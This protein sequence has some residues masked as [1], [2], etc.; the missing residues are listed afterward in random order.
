MRWN[1]V[2]FAILLALHAAIY[3]YGELRTLT[4]FGNLAQGIAL[5]LAGLQFGR[6]AQTS[7]ER[8]VRTFNFIALGFFVCLMGHG[9]LAYSEL[10]LHQPATG[11]V[12]DAIWL[13]GYALI[14]QSLFFRTGRDLVKARK[15]KLHLGL[16]TLVSMI[17]CV[18]LWLPLIDPQRSALTK[19]L[20]VIF[21]FLDFWI[22]AMAFVLY[23]RTG[24]RGWLLSGI[25]SLIIGIAD[26]V[27]PY[28]YE[29]ISPVYRYL[30]IPLFIGYSMW[31]LGG[32]SM[33]A[34]SVEPVS[35]NSA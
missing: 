4:W 10:L 30:D 31:W 3:P 11:T 22:S 28:F 32:A 26:L 6:S 29:N 20:Q 1:V 17:V 12:T 35:A 24:I 18:A 15:V 34:K 27:F 19:M 8:E 25:G 21:P 7:D 14:A 33:K 16:L 5:L 13:V 9:L 2:L 23:K